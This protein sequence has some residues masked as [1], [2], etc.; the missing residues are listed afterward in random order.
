MH[1]AIVTN[2]LL[3]LLPFSLAIFNPVSIFSDAKMDSI[4]VVLF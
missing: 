1:L 4:F 2:E 3:S